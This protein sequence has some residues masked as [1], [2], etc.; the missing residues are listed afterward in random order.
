MV[1]T[2]LVLLAFALKFQKNIITIPSRS[3][4]AIQSSSVIFFTKLIKNSKA[5]AVLFGG[6]L[7]VQFVF[8]HD[9]ITISA[10][11]LRPF[12]DEYIALTSNVEFF[13]NLNFTAGD[14][15]GGNYSIYLTSGPISALGSVIGWNFS[16]NIVTTRI[17]NYYW[18]VFLQIIFLF[19][20]TNKSRKN[21][22]FLILISV[23]FIPLIPWWIGLMYSIGEVA[24][25]L[26]FVNAIFL[27]KT[28]KKLSFFL[29]GLSIIFGKLL[30]VIPFAGF[31]IFY[32]WS[33]KKIKK[34]L[35]L[36]TYFLIPF[37]AWFLLVNLNYENGNLLDYLSSQ[38]DLIS[39]H[40]SSGVK[41]ISF[42][43]IESFRDTLLISEYS[44]W[45]VYD[46]TRLLIVPVLFCILIYKNRLEINKVFG[47]IAIP[48]V[49]S[50][51]LTYIWFWLMSPT[52]WIRYSQHF[53]II[54]IFSLIY[55]F[56]SKLLHSNFDFLLSLMLFS[57]FIEDEKF[58]IYVTF[59]IGIILLSVKTLEIRVIFGKTVLIIILFLNLGISYFQNTNST[60]DTNPS[61]ESCIK[62]LL[63]NKC[64]EEFTLED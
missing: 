14:F 49:G 55:I 46:K 36:L 25:V 18:I 33:N 62:T 3:F 34:S 61:I 51:S 2:I 5:K 39:N 45:N 31:F 52:K 32:S 57:V 38:Y 28:N 21:I 19:L 37:G 20:I 17:A 60:Y 50:V 42:W 23:F 53:T 6:L 29:M 44:T 56:N 27:L 13:K 26:I 63:D 48:I 64:R 30:T 15:I 40:Q 10:I 43:S 8:I 41:E 9:Y 47:E 11:K 1:L 12:V 54:I 22:K 58:L 4:S 59:F 35:K 24:S 7:L 16:N